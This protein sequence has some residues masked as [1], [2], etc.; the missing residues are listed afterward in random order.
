MLF[1][2][3]GVS[4]RRRQRGCRAV[5][6]LFLA[7]LFAS[8]LFLTQLEGDSKERKGRRKRGGWWR[9]P[10]S[11]FTCVHNPS[12]IIMSTSL[13]HMERMKGLKHCVWLALAFLIA[14]GC[15]NV[16][17]KKWLDSYRKRKGL[18]E[19]TGKLQEELWLIV[20]GSALGLFSLYMVTC[21]CENLISY[22]ITHHLFLSFV[23]RFLHFLYIQ[24]C[25]R[26]HFCSCVLLLGLFLSTL[27]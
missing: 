18:K 20:C 17:T 22:L 15:M 1:I 2:A 16:T 19:S 4:K 10:R 24:P 27:V 13:F 6:C 21:R 8:Y 14:R 9:E 11:S 7:P 3:G 12:S 26:F 23:D 5:P 25:F